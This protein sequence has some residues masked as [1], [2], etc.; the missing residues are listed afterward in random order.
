MSNYEAGYY[1]VLISTANAVIQELQ[2]GVLVLPSQNRPRKSVLSQ[3]NI[4]D[5]RKD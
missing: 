2:T 5:S 4:R 1:K 3:A